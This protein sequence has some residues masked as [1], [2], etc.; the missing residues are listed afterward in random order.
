[1]AGSIERKANGNMSI[2]ERIAVLEKKVDDLCAEKQTKIKK[3]IGIGDDFH[4][5]GIRWKI[6]DITDQGYLCHAMEPWKKSKFDGNSNN[7]AESELR[8]ELFGLAE[9]IAKKSAWIIS[10][11]SKGI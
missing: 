6:L 11:L 2:E 9:E 10:S 5:T 8:R 1:M 3:N 4:L 7:W